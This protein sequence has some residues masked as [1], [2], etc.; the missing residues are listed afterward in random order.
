MTLAGRVAWIT[1]AGSGIGLAAAR[2][3]A[4][5]SAAVVLSARRA[6]PLAHAAAALRA[7]GAQAQE[8]P[9]DVT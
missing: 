7:A 6:E 9:L 5:A 4:A 8:A 1:G 2:E 3:L